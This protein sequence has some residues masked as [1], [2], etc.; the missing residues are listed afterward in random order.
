MYDPQSWWALDWI[1]KFLMFENG[2]QIDMVLNGDFAI[3]G[4]FPLNPSGGV[5]SSNPIGATAIIRVAEA[6]LQIRGNAGDHQVPKDIDLALSS[7]FGGTFWTVF[8][9]LG[10]EKPDK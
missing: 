1:G 9:L 8:H 3:D 10:A 5:V 4:K 2:E 6:A 7:G